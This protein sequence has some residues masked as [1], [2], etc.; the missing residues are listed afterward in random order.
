[1]EDVNCAGTNCEEDSIVSNDQV[2][3]FLG[4]VLIFLGQ[5]ATLWK[6]GEGVD[7]VEETAKPARCVVR[8]LLRNPEVCLLGFGGSAGLEDDL[9][10]H[11]LRPRPY[12]ERIVFLKSSSGIP[13]PF[14]MDSMPR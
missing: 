12:F 8:R 4:K 14:F 3:D 2:A 5:R 1:M 13:S 10:F 9:V 11:L 7:R 6:I